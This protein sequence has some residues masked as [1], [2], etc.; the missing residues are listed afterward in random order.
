MALRQDH[1]ARN[2][3]ANSVKRLR[4]TVSGYHADLS[5]ANMAVRSGTTS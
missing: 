3:A 2:D 4:I 5:N 1:R